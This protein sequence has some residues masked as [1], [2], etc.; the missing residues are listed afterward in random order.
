VTL[1]ADVSRCQG[2]TGIGSQA[3]SC[4]LRNGCE[5]FLT[6]ITERDMQ[7][8]VSELLCGGKVLG[9]VA[10]DFNYPFFIPAEEGAE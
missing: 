8:P 1:P 6:L 3:T 9:R 4:S 2:S 5:R 10:I 7:T